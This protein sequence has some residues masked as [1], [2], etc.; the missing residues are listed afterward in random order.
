MDITSSTQCPDKSALEAKLSNTILE[1]M[2]LKCVQLREEVREGN[3][4]QIETLTFME[5]VTS[6]R[7]EIIE[8]KTKCI[9]LIIRCPSLEA[10]HDLND[11]VTTKTL[12][13]SFADTF[14][15]EE[16][17]ASHGIAS[18]DVEMTICPLEY[19]LCERE[20][21]GLGMVQSPQYKLM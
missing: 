14:F 1:I 4:S 2:T 10:L 12:Q 19:A 13:A 15:T 16:W 21:T 3:P 18:I 9:L 7:K 17:K 20:L 8:L 6:L 11:A 5:R